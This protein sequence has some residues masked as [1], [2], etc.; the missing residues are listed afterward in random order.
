[1]K[2]KNLFFL[3]S[4]CI[5]PRKVPYPTTEDQLLTGPFEPTN[6]S[7]AIAKVAGIRLAQSYCRQF[8]KNFISLMP[9]NLYGPNDRYD[10]EDSHV[11]PSILLKVLL[12][13]REGKPELKLWGSG[14]PLREFLH[15]DDL[16][17]AL[18]L[19]LERYN[20]PEIINIGSGDETTIKELAE[21]IIR[22]CDYKGELRWDFS[23]PDGIPRKVLDSSKIQA[24]GWQRKISLNQGLSTILED[25]LKAAANLSSNLK[26]ALN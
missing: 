17:E 23:K 5:Y 4:A 15:S 16:A 21:K 12:A 18:L 9:T 20:D 19:C 25:G 3:G 13:K 7:Y 8:G 11:I 2:S 22:L 24:L 26:K 1:M 14:K 6:E 10:L